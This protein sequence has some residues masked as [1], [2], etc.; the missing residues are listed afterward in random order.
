MQQTD[1]ERQLSCET[2]LLE[3]DLKSAD[4]AVCRSSGQGRIAVCIPGV[5]TEAAVSGL[6]CRVVTKEE[7]ADDPDA[8]AMDISG[9]R[10]CGS[11]WFAEIFSVFE[12]CWPKGRPQ[13]R[14]MNLS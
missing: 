1:L 5:G 4:R 3:G 11:Q 10:I 13:Q 2:G 6:L 9:V 7:R 12:G 14:E 8:V